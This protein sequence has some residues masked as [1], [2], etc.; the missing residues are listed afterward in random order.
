MTGAVR[1]RPAGP[2]DLPDVLR[3]IGELAAYEREPDAVLA[4]AADLHDALFPA[5]REPAAFC[6]LAVEDPGGTIGMA[7]WFL[8]FSTWEGR[9]GIWVEDLYVAPS[10]RGRGAGRALLAELARIAVD[11]GYRRLEWSVLDWNEPA[12][13]FY[14]RLGA[15]GMDGWTTQRLDGPALAALA[16]PTPG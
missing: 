3:C 8:T 9:H 16:R 7:L 14:R 13:T 6:H 12:I 4:T 2:D 10:H 1:V 5:H 15:R 11:R